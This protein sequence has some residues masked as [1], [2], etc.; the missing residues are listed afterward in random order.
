MRSFLVLVFMLLSSMA[1]SEFRVED[2]LESEYLKS[3]SYLILDVVSVNITHTIYTDADEVQMARYYLVYMCNTDSDYS[4]HW[5]STS[6]EPLNN[7]N[8][9]GMYKQEYSTMAD[10]DEFLYIITYRYK[11][12][13]QWHY[14]DPL[15]YTEY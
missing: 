2:T 5:Y 1:F 15:F 4:Q 3:D 9:N 10:P 13:N 11:I 7:S 12:T 14:T 8:D 6:W